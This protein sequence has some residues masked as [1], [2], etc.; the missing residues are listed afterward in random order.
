MNKP[1][2]QASELGLVITRIFEAPRELVFKAWTEPERVSQWWGPRGFTSAV[3][4]LDVR[5]G[6][7][8]TMQMRGP[9]GGVYPLNGIFQEIVPPERLVFAT[10]T[11][12]DESGNP[13][14]EVLN[15]VTFTD[16]G[17]KTRLT[18]QAR[19]V[20]STPEVAGL[21]A[22]MEEGWVQAFDRLAET[23]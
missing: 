20:K 6:G 1:N 14:L 10:S 22:G 5:P 9:D 12:E 3:H 18:L 15:I 8:I 11:F 2:T 17:G 7:R 4:E 19:V 16:L 21:L 13:Q 23:L